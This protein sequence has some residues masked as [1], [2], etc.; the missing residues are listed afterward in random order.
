M[1]FLNLEFLVILPCNK[2]EN[3]VDQ[4]ERD[5]DVSSVLK[6]SFD[7]TMVTVV[8]AADRRQKRVCLAAVGDERCRLVE[9]L[10]QVQLEPFVIVRLVLQ[11]LKFT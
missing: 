8:A 9:R 11:L 4:L 3:I 6:R 2:I 5:P 1:T 7:E 10:V